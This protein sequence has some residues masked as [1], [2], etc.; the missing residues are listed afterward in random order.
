[1][2]QKW[3]NNIDLQQNELQNG[4]IQNLAADPTSGKAGQIYYNTV[5]K[6]YRYHNGTEWVSITA[7]A[8]KSI[9]AGNGLT[10]SGTGTVTISLG[11]PSTSGAT[12]GTTYGSND[13][14]E[15][16]HTH[17]I[18]I[19]AAT[20]DTPGVV[21]LATDAE[22]T[23]GTDTTKAIN[24]KQLKD[25]KQSAIDSAK[26]TIQ[27]SN[28][29]TGG[30]TTPGNSFTLSGVNASTEAKGVVQLAA[31]NDT[32]STDKAVTP[33]QLETARK[34]AEVSITAGNGLTGG[35]TGHSLSVAMG[36][37]STVNQT[38]TN[39]TTATSHTHELKFNVVNSPA[40]SGNEISFIDTVSQGAN[41]GISA[42][43]KTVRSA[44]AT[45]TGVVQL[46]SQDEVNTGTDTTKVITPATLGKGKASG[47]ASL[48]ANSKIIT[49]QLPDYLLGQ[50]MYGGNASTVATTTIIS[51]SDSLK[52]KKN[53]T[54]TSISIENSA[55][56]TKDNTYGYKDMEGVYFICQA[57]GTFAGNSFETGDWIISTGSAWEKIDNTDAVTSVNGQIGDVNI[58]KVDK[59]GTADKVAQAL[60]IG[61]SE[62]DTGKDVKYDGLGAKRVRFDKDDFD[63]TTVLPA[64]D[65][66]FH[67]KTTGVAAGNYNNI[68]VD[69]KGRV[70]AGKRENYA[71]TIVKTFS[72]D[73]ST[74]IFDLPHSLN[75]DVMVQIYLTGQTV[76]SDTVDELVMTDVYTAVGKI[77]VVFASAPGTSQNFKAV[78]TGM[79]PS[80]E[81]MDW[82]SIRSV[83]L[84]G[85]A[86]KYLS[87]GDTKSV[88][89]KSGKTYTIRVA[90]MQNGRYDYSDNSGSSKV[91][92][93]F[94]ETYNL[95]GT[96]N[97]KIDSD[98]KKSW[99]TCLLR[100]ETMPL[101]L[102]D[103][104]DDLV[105]AISEVKVLSGTAGNASGGVISSNDKL[106]LPAE[107]EVF[108]TNK[109]SL[110]MSES[111][112][113]QF[114]YYKTNNTDAA[115]IK[116]GVGT[117]TA[118][119][120]WGRSPDATRNYY[121]CSVT[122]GGQ[123]RSI[124]VDNGCGVSPIFA[125]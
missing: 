81:E 104:P 26:V 87:V 20:T 60:T 12:S 71:Q 112:F 28:G 37:P 67:L 42:T 90:D 99:S 25:A 69:T 102:A 110:G 115:R 88:T 84:A 114:D 8:V 41:G 27:T 58:T 34:K 57:S 80:F 21:E 120:W 113:G 9:V 73:G 62:L 39:S 82:T 75:K 122:N 29:I 78:I 38:T 51:P 68:T 125:I 5:G 31:D 106:F 36:T 16:S 95:N 4:V 43:K 97:W 7:E 76:G 63:Y 98:T 15:T 45:Q 24:A 117:T 61:P 86:A 89:S 83:I 44:S 52:T 33:K 1:M 56:S 6:G 54:T 100:R 3:F 70:V 64:D 66:T 47:V 23:A 17:Q 50:V 79:L 49:S 55:T 72:G 14:T 123:L 118:A 91:T 40:A 2:S 107:V 105:A 92:F 74:T 22:A 94:V 30:S 48:D 85:D 10:S 46:A 65:I 101:V 77:K 108:D 59:A 124:T 53:I 13:V 19:S 18:R 32:T 96:L 111:P 35:G 116:H 109:D 103:L 11:T 121:W 119:R 93:E